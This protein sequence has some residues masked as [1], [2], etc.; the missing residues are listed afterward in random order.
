[1][2]A[3][4]FNN[5]LNE[6]EDIE[7]KREAVFKRFASDL[8]QV[9]DKEEIDFVIDILGPD[10]M[11]LDTVYEYLD[12]KLFSSFELETMNRLLSECGLIGSKDDTVLIGDYSTQYYT[13][14]YHIQFNNGLDA[15]LMEDVYDGYED[16]EKPETTKWLCLRRSDFKRILEVGYDDFSFNSFLDDWGNANENFRDFLQASEIHQNPGAWDY[17]G[18]NPKKKKKKINNRPLS[19]RT[20]RRRDD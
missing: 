17:Y 18:L 6:S 12:R 3:K 16:E 2:R 5:W 10:F 15:V 8:A 14:I 9:T 13:D 11:V 1:M 4:T 19:R 20:R 7:L